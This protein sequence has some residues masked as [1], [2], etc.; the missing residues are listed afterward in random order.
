MKG[1]GNFSWQRSKVLTVIMTG[2]RAVSLSGEFYNLH[3]ALGNVA[4]R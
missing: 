1:L 3:L 2:R 4:Q